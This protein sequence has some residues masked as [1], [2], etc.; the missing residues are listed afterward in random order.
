MTRRGS[1]RPVT[2]LISHPGAE[3]FARFRALTQERNGLIGDDRCVVTGKVLPLAVDV[4]AGINKLSLSDLC[5]PIVIAGLKA[6]V[7]VHVPLADMS[8]SIS[9]SVQCQRQ[10]RRFLIPT[11][12]I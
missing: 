10:R 11:G 4:L 3:G 2:G 5:G 12:L 9:P 6:I 8:G 7:A 1:E